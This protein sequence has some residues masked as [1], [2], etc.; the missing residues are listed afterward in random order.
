MTQRRKAASRNYRVYIDTLIKMNRLRW[1]RGGISHPKL[2]DQ[3]VDAGLA[4][5]P[6]NMRRE[7]EARFPDNETPDMPRTDYFTGSWWA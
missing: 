7:A 1:I 4:M 3:L 5:E 2:L 6:E